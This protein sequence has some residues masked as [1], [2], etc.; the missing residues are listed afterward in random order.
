MAYQRGAYHR[1][2]FIIMGSLTT[3]EKE[4]EK[5]INQL[6]RTSLAIDEARKTILIKNKEHNREKVESDIDIDYLD[7][8][9]P[10][11]DKRRGEA[12]VLLALARMH[13]K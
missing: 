5:L 2:S 3:A 8:K 10:K 9:F 4:I 1:P 7:K 12:M 13:G 6:D 11:G